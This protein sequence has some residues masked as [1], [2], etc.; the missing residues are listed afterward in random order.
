MCEHSVV[1]HSAAIH[2]WHPDAA[3]GQVGGVVGQSVEDAVPWCWDVHFDV[4]PLI[5]E[6]AMPCCDVL[7]QVVDV[8]ARGGKLELLHVVLL[9]VDLLDWGMRVLRV[10]TSIDSEV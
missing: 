8:V 9:A 4:E 6:E 1:C 10:R 5:A 2:G 3:E 7:R